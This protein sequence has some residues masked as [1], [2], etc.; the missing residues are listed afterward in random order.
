VG[1]GYQRWW[2][3]DGDERFRYET[4]TEPGACEVMNDDPIVFRLRLS[5][6]SLDGGCIRCGG[7]A[8]VL[9]DAALWCWPDAVFYLLDPRRPFSYTAPK[10]NELPGLGWTF[11]R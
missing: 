6:A 4:A 11:E 9:M 8:S 2:W 3:A 5:A 7:P 10:A 1:A